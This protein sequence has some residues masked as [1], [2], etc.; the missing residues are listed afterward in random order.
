MSTVATLVVRVAGDMKDA[1]KAFAGLEHA[2][3][4]LERA[5]GGLG[6]SLSAVGRHAGQGPR[7]GPSGR[8]RRPPGSAL[9]AVQTGLGKVGDALAP[10]TSALPGSAG[11]A[12]ALA[13][14][15]SAALVPVGAVL[16]GHRPAAWSR[17]AAS[18]SGSSAAWSRSG[19]AR[20]NAGD[21]LLVLS[22]QSGIS[23]ENLS[24]F[25]YVEQQTDAS[26][27]KIVGS[28]RKLGHQPRHRR[29][30]K[31]A[32][33]SKR[34]GLSLADVREAQA[35]GSLHRRSSRA[36]ARSPRP[37]SAP[38][39][40]PRSSARAGT[41]SRS[42]RTEDLRGLMT[43]ADIFG[44]TISTELAVAGDRFNDTLGQ[45]STIFEGLEARDRGRRPAGDDGLRRSAARPGDRRAAEDRDHDGD[46]A[47]HLRDVRAQGRRWRC[48]RSPRAVARGLAVI[49]RICSSKPIISDS[50]AVSKRSSGSSAL[51]SVLKGSIKLDALDTAGSREA[52]AAR[53]RGSRRPPPRWKRICRARSRGSRRRLPP[54]RRP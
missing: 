15:P 41:T 44:A 42:S 30:R 32:R 51:A 39:P 26:V 49:A 18:R 21:E 20:P 13:G 14:R 50:T 23:V 54:R 17:W 6:T 37:A 19:R 33:P 4:G 53:R 52:Q 40:A 46:G 16:G 3:K 38:R 25:Q 2:G 45:L 35:G 12:G 8:C 34:I 48:C 31:P 22:Q 27:D 7:A 43:E 5:C 28:I 1:E 11:H 47:G 36:S 24:R 10:L 29:A 9:G